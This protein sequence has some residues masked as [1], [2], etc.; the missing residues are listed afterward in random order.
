MLERPMATNSSQK[1]PYPYL[2]LQWT[3]DK[4]S[5]LG[6]THPKINLSVSKCKDKEGLGVRKGINTTVKSTYQSSIHV[7]CTVLIDLT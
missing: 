7:E 4:L 1:H 6:S 5:K 3:A 2:L